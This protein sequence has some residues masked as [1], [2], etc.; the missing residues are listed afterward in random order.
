MLPRN[1]FNVSAETAK[2]LGIGPAL[3][4][5]IINQYLSYGETMNQFGCEYR[6]GWM[7]I[8]LDLLQ[9]EMEWWSIA[10]ISRHVNACV[11]Y[12]L[13]DSTTH[14]NESPIDKSKWYRWKEAA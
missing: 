6:D 9:R 3:V 8:P 2:A 1:F 10:Q 7:R 11:E 12:G 4:E 13:F 14:L 5:S